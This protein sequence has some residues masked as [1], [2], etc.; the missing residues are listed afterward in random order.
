MPPIIS[1][2][3]LSKTYASGLQALKSVDLEIERGEIFGLLGPNGAGKT[4]LIGIVCGTVTATTGTVT[5]AG[6]DIGRDFRAARSMIGL[7]PQ[8]LTAGAFET[9]WATVSFT[10]GLFGKPPSPAII[11]R[12]LRDLSLWEKRDDK[13]VTLSGGMKRRVLIA[14]ALSHEPEI[15]FLDEPT[16]G[17]DVELRRDMWELVRGLRERG[18]TI[19][20]TTHYLEEAEE[21]ADRIGVILK[22]ELILVEEKARLMQK[23]GKKQLTL[24][25]TEPLAAL[26]EWPGRVAAGAQERRHRAAIHLRR[27]R[28]A[29]RRAVAAAPRHRP[30]PALLRP[31]HAP[32]L[33]RGHLRQ[34]GPGSRMT[35]NWH[36]IVAIYRFEMQRS[37]RTLWQSV[38]APVLTTSLYFIV[39]G[40]AIGSKMSVVGGVPYGAFI[41]PGLIMLALFTQSISNASFGIYFP[42]FTGTIYEI[43]SA[44]I[45]AFEIV[46][47]YVGA[48]ATKSIVLGLIILATA[49]MFVEVRIQHP[50][51]MVAFLLLTAATF[52][53]F[54]FIIGI[55]AQG[56]EQLQFIPLLIIT[57]L[58]F[59]GGTFYSI[60]M[61]P[62]FW[63]TVTL[64][65]PLVYLINGF[66]WSFYG[67]SDVAVGV[68][69]SMTL[70]FFGLCLAVVAWMFRTGYRLKS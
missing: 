33:A 64:F 60:D 34:P 56:F 57:P 3:N 68:S 28:R 61:L 10:R 36:A 40:A 69:L 23:L 22:G 13:I 65:N 38:V 8:E 49:A 58:T 66:R 41:V 67:A 4:T 12:T 47:A 5:V 42:K 51:F 15:L 26:P 59:L 24:S 19:I 46:T 35:V 17:V 2:Q 20:L 18:V 63:R 29:H 7:V 43:L 44:P 27:Q 70:L 9:V 31:Q 32:E 50:F 1:I 54:G 30:G 16:A 6:H 55:W 39:F 62:P 53:L 21:M 14:K 25:L 11:E 48:A 45:S 52:S 37:L